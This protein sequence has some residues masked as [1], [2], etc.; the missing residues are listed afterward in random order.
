MENIQKLT[1]A[2][3]Q[4]MQILWSINEGFL[5]DIVE[6]FN[7]PKPHSNT[8]ATLLKIL[9]DKN[10]VATK[11]YGRSNLYFALV[12]KEDYSKA[13]LTQLVDGYFEGNFSNAVSFMVEKND[14]SIKDLE[15]LLKQL[16]QGK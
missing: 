14:I 10:F 12:K 13:S 16:Q 3:E 6:Q 7:N 9:V 1:K 8:I 5:K 11:T 15:M 2:E 4:V